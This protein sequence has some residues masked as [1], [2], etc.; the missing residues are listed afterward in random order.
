M[1]FLGEYCY[2]VPSGT[3]LYVSNEKHCKILHVG[4]WVNCLEEIPTYVIYVW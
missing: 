2:V 3:L 1:K 4:L